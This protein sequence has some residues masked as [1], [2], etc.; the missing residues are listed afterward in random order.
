MSSGIKTI[1]LLAAAIA[2]AG[3]ASQEL[4]AGTASNKSASGALKSANVA[5][6]TPADLQVVTAQFGVFGADPSGR[7]LLYETDKF[8]AIPAAPYGWYILFK[9]NK[10]TVIGARNSSCQKRPQ[11]GARRSDGN[12]QHFSRSQDCSD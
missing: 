10:P 8:P 4:A 5:P 9:T 3:C 1:T 12:F 7:R 11:P 2:I 6:L